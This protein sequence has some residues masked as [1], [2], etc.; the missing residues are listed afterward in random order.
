V[1]ALD[2]EHS[3]LLQAKARRA[4]IRHAILE[5][6]QD[7]AGVLRARVEAED[8]TARQAVLHDL[9]LGRLQRQIVEHEHLVSQEI[10][11]SEAGIVA[12]I[13]VRQGAAVIAGEALLKV[14]RPHQELEAWLYL[15]SAKAGFLRTGQL[16][17]LR[18]DAY[19]HQLFGTSSAEVISVSSIAIVPREAGVPLPLNGPVFEVR[20]R[21]KESTVEAFNAIWPLA[22]GTSF[23]ADLVQRRYR[24]YEWLLRVVKNGSGDQRA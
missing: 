18:L 5:Y 2:Q 13:N 7:T 3:S 11:A 20:A 14:Y 16:V 8:E 23:Q 19:P 4:A 24:L 17:E 1:D 6:E 10:R 22:P 12:R 15:S 9:E 21:L